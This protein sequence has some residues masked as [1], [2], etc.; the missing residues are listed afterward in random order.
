M[1][2]HATSATGVSLQAPDPQLPTPEQLTPEL[3]SRER[4]APEQLTPELLRAWAWHKQGLD[5]SLRGAD[6]ADVF[7]RAGWARSVGGANPY[8]T[9]FA[10]AGT[11]RAQ[12]DADV[13]SLKIH[14]LPTARGCTY[15]L[16]KDDFAWGLQ[17]GRDAAVAPFRVLAR[18][19]VERG[20]ITLLEEQILH[21]LADAGGP[22]DPKQLKE[23]L[24]ESVRNLGEEGKKK[25]AATTLPTALG[26]LQADGRI[27]R[28]PV[29]GRL[30]Q[31]RY[32]Y[33]LWGLPPTAT[34]DDAARSLLLERYLGWTGGATV[35]QSQWFTGFTLAHTKAAFA[36]IAAMES[37]TAHGEVLWML[38]D[39]VERLAAFE[40]PA[41]EQ[42]QLLA[43]TDS[44]ILLR[45]NSGDLFADQDKGKQIL[46]STLDLQADLP[47]HPIFDR[48]RI[49]G[50]WQYDPGKA[51]IASWLFGSPTPAVTQ[52][53]DEVE[54]W[55]RDELGDFRSFSLDSPA[56]RQ[57]RIDALDAAG[58]AA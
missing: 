16:G 47:D 31:Q 45:R 52:R 9:L 49:I 19:G 51:R 40:A 12:A 34:A 7:T 5:G 17:I 30:D 58:Q 55:I 53:I 57:D 1:T 46:G 56:S 27:R 21:A 4:P 38:P 3:T 50:L 22:L 25:G 11:R 43:G 36:A 20:E 24:G 37:P 54:A 8:L 6:A 2:T 41:Q 13:L 48:G 42:I 14:E 15:V 29:N 39:D 10:R 32:S 44:L 23:V 26:L 28:V 33:A 35:K 18:M